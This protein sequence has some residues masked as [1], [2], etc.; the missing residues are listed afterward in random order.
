MPG[1]AQTPQSLAAMLDSIYEENSKVAWQLWNDARP[2]G[3]PSKG[4]FLGAFCECLTES[5]YYYDFSN[6]LDN[7]PPTCFAKYSWFEQTG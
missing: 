7:A 5:R 3:K 1:W 6:L 4:G 2:P